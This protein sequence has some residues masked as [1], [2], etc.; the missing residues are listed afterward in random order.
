MDI[1]QFLTAYET[2]VKGVAD[3]ALI[4]QTFA[5]LFERVEGS[6]LE[7]DFSKADDKISRLLCIDKAAH[8]IHS[9]DPDLLAF[10]FPEADPEFV[11][12]T[13]NRLSGLESVSSVRKTSRGYFTT[14][15]STEGLAFLQKQVGELKVTKATRDEIREDVSEY[16]RLFKAG[17][18]SHAELLTLARYHGEGKN[19]RYLDEIKKKSFTPDDPMVVGGYA[20]VEV[21][22]KEG[23]LITTDALR[24]AFGRFMDSFRTRNVNFAH[25]LKPET[26]VWKV[27]GGYVPISS[28]KQGD[29][30]LTD[31]GRP[32]EVEDVIT[33]DFDS[34]IN[35]FELANGEVIKV[36]DEH[37]ILTKRG[38][39]KAK[40]ILVTDVLLKAVLNG[41]T[42]TRQK[43]SEAKKGKQGGWCNPPRGF[44]IKNDSDQRKG[45]TWSEM[46]GH[47]KPYYGGNDGEQNPNWKGGI[48]R[49]PYTYEYSVKKQSI[50]DRD[51]HRCRL[52]G[53]TESQEI[54]E[55]NRQLSVHH[56]DYI[57]SHDEDLNLIT[58]CDKCNS[59][60]NFDRD[61]WKG[62]FTEMLS[63]VLV[64]NGTSIVRITKEHY[65]GKVWNLHVHEDH[66]YAGK[67]IIY[68]N[69]DVQ[70]GW[71][72]R[73][74]INNDGEIYKSGVDDRG[75]YLVSEV[76]PDITI[77]NKVEKEIEA[78]IIRS[79][80]IAGSALD[81]SVETKGGR[82]IMVV[83]DLE[84][85]EISFCEK[86][87]NQESNFDI[88]KSFPSGKV[89]GEMLTKDQVL[90][91]FPNGEIP[92]TDY[93]VCMVG[94][95]IRNGQ[96]VNDVDVVVRADKDSFIGRAIHLMLSRD[97]PVEV[98]DRVRFIFEPEGPHGDYIPLYNI[99]LCPV[100]RREV[101]LMALSKA[102]QVVG[103]SDAELK[104]LGE[105]A[106]ANFN[107]NISF[108][109]FKMGVQV[110][111][112]HY[113][114]TE[115][116]PIKTAKIALAHI[117][118]VP[119]YYTKLK[120]VESGDVKK[121]IKFRQSEEDPTK[122]EDQ[123]D[124]DMKKDSDESGRFTAGNNEYRVRMHPQSN[125]YS[126]DHRELNDPRGV[127]WYGTATGLK[128][129]AEA[130]GRIKEHSGDQNPKGVDQKL[131]KDSSGDHSKTGGSNE[132]STIRQSPNVQTPV[133]KV[134]EIHMCE[135]PKKKGLDGLK[136]FVDRNVNVKKDQ[137]PAT[138]PPKLGMVMDPI[139]HR[140]KNP[141][142]IDK[143]ETTH[144]TS[145]H[146]E[147]RTHIKVTWGKPET[148]KSVTDEDISNMAAFLDFI[149]DSKDS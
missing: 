54:D 66:T 100:A 74:W 40:D 27:S 45:K 3:D 129:P 118:E 19:Q 63:G 67:G 51:G 32:R 2:I 64:Q 82:V 104:K 142:V 38:W 132:Q 5:D 10:A 33:H 141:K 123:N 120:M 97:L 62:F 21:V 111:L 42:E 88:I 18:A 77:A 78:G 144:I 80:S 117:R 136:E 145:S 114:L 99:R 91:M 103:M 44:C 121:D 31:K 30:V 116:D 24:K 115:M 28:I 92:L 39:V 138:H 110:E 81:K 56:I 55:L 16:E 1:Q 87:V 23:H 13:L 53:K 106:G 96:S 94:G 29:Y 122:P 35:V 119:D 70:A 72:L 149:K 140:W 107:T 112:E 105:E 137:P 93:T 50:L 15:A 48:A 125:L 59:K 9:K 124:I 109:E 34:L 60:V 84:L 131:S 47:E 75:L 89:L 98:R 113:D 71:P 52:C 101:S 139:S 73:V 25:C 8:F 65:E 134:G 127:K 108:E 17:I 36:T 76:R 95:L 11:K 14:F 130:F 143:S 49:L 46:Y 37:P 22:D 68:H 90:G 85:A 102:D 135:E 4:D 126:V 128:T 41:G 86:P 26:L 57:K 6:Y 7:D 133:T 20:S 12:Q 61:M 43:M 79:Y 58:L 83:N 148:K 146:P 147:K 69:S